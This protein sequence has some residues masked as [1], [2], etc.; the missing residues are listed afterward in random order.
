MYNDVYE[1]TLD[2]AEYILNNKSTIRATA[3]YFNI[4]KSTVHY[5]LKYKLREVNLDMYDKVK[6]LLIE[7]FNEKHIRGGLA[8]KQKYINEKIIELQDDLCC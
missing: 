8:T 5:Y 6:K 4:A 2:M 1:L 7:N 3:K